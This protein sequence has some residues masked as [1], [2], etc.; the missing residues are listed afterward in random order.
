MRV[1]RIATKYRKRTLSLQ[2]GLSV[3]QRQHA[4]SFHLSR[5]LVSLHKLSGGAVDERDGVATTRRDHV[6]C[7]VLFRRIRLELTTPNLRGCIRRVI[8]AVTF[9]EG[10]AIAEVTAQE[11]LG[12]VV[13]TLRLKASKH[14]SATLNNLVQL[15]Y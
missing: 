15:R 10:F 13:V 9:A 8:L 1:R 3:K 12:V 7:L 11:V 4:S 2:E 14:N 5:L 6:S